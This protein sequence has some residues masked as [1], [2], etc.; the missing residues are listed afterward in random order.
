MIEGKNDFFQMIDSDDND[1]IKRR[2]FEEIPND[3]VISND[4]GCIQ[5]I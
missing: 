1:M 4:V 2:F 5:N 3:D